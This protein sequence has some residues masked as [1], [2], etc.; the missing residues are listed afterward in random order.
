MSWKFASV[1]GALAWAMPAVAQAAEG[2]GGTVVDGFTVADKGV[3]GVWVLANVS[4]AGMRAQD[5]VKGGWRTVAFIFGF[6]GTLVSLLAVG[7]G[8]N[9]AYGVSLPRN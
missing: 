6:P 7:E 5:H 9:R 8:S 1:L 3:S 4:Y 2:S